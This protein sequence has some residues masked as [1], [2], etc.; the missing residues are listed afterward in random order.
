[1]TNPKGRLDGKIAIVTGAGGGFGEGIAKLFADE[2]AKVGVLDLRADA[3]ERV[4]SEIGASAIALTADVTSREQIEQAVNKM[5]DA[6]G[7][8]DV[9]VNNAG[10]THRNKP[11]LDVT[12]EEFDRVYAINVK[13]IYHISNVIVPLMREN[14][15][16][17]IVNI[18]SVAGIRPRPGLTWYNSTKGAVNILSQSMAVELAPDKIR[19]NAICPVMGETGLLESFMGQPDTPENRAKFVSTIPLGRMSRPDD[20]ARATLYL[21]SD[22]AAFITGVLLPVDGGRT[23]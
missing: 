4:A 16:G 15:G 7:T 20:I 19:V 11:M 17:S 8:P 2:G 12:E 14:G 10:W 1:M 23:V 18:G 6:F 3:A 9:F 22:D 13:S 5:V 21:S